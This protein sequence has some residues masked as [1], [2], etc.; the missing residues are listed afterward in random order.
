[1]FFQHA[2]FDLLF[3]TP[4]CPK[5]EELFVSAHGDQKV[6]NQG[7]TSFY[8]VPFIQPRGVANV[9]VHCPKIRSLNLAGLNHVDDTAFPLA[10]KP[11]DMMSNLSS[12]NLS[13]C[14]SI[15]DD[16]VHVIATHC[17]SLKSLN[18][19]GAYRIVSLLQL[20]YQLKLERLRSASSAEIVSE[21]CADT[22]RTTINNVSQTDKALKSIA[23]SRCGPGS[24]PGLRKRSILLPFLSSGVSSVLEELN[25]MKCTNVT[26]IGVALLASYCSNLRALNVRGCIQLTDK[27]ISACLRQCKLL[28]S[29]SIASLLK[30]TPAAFI[31]ANYS[32]RTFQDNGC[33]KAIVHGTNLSAAG[34]PDSSGQIA[35]RLTASCT[36]PFDKL[37]VLNVYGM[38]F[39]VVRHKER[40]RER[41][42]REGGRKRDPCYRPRY[43]R[44]ITL[45]SPPS[46]FSRSKSIASSAANAHQDPPVCQN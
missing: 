38:S 26:D 44:K 17:W 13:G 41:R 30:V 5:L 2:C 34:I 16:A 14:F 45:S 32:N 19:S 20:S 6:V 15:G 9:L 33:R 24:E 12:L 43:G 3:K 28:R 8:G 29:F 18:L 31:F 21:G 37:E 42:E 11:A 35:R 23:C 40:E 4:D 39:D 25:I 7:L 22:P 27:S 36:L 10:R 46:P 1:M